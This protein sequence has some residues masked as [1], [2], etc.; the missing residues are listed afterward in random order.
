MNNNISFVRPLCMRFAKHNTSTMGQDF[1]P[2]FQIASKQ[3][4]MNAAL[5]WCFRYSG[6]AIQRFA[7]G[8]IAMRTQ[9]PSSDAPPIG[10]VLRRKCVSLVLV[11]SL[12]TGGLF[13]PTTQAHDNSV[14]D[15]VI[16]ISSFSQALNERAALVRF[17][18]GA[19]WPE[20]RGR[21]PNSVADYYAPTPNDALP[22]NLS[23]L[24][25]IEKLISTLS[26]PLSNGATLV[27]TSTAF[28]FHPKNR[29]GRVVVVHHGHGCE[30]NG[31]D[32]PYHLDET[33]RDLLSSGF[34]VVAMR[35]PLYQSPSQCGSDAGDSSHDGLMNR[36]LKIGS[37]LKFFLEP[38]ARV[39]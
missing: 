12:F 26:E 24:D 38:V 11:G 32:G 35:M 31:A 1:V 16:K 9:D 10:T 3:G 4:P 30:F 22:V 36:Q 18:W 28:V 13:A 15:H 17:I 14:D 8:G 27:H 2:G 23:N 5:K 6:T 29:N 21:F 19:D 25:R 33:V 7:H 20:V 37:P 39:L 34:A